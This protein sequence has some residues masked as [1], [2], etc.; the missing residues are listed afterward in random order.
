V[1]RPCFLSGT[2]RP[3]RRS[4][5]SWPPLAPP[6][7]LYLE[8]TDGDGQADRR[9]VLVEGFALG[10]TDSNANSLRYGLDG[11]VHAANGG[12][13]GRLW[14]PGA[15]GEPVATPGGKA[16]GRGKAWRGSG[17]ESTQ[18]TSRSSARSSL[19]KCHWPG[20]PSGLGM[21]HAS[22]CGRRTATTSGATTSS[23]IGRL[24][25]GRSGC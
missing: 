25:F 14:F 17:E 18:L 8:D 21:G 15:E 3:S 13:G 12:N 24:E 11:L 9:E 4:C 10:V 6:Q 5:C 19:R 2:A 1:A 16:G 7:L 23:W 22:G 20:Y